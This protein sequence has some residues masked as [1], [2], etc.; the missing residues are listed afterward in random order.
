VEAIKD[1]EDKLKRLSFK[2]KLVEIKPEPAAAG[3]GGD[4]GEEAAESSGE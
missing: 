3:V 1:D 2:G 4:G